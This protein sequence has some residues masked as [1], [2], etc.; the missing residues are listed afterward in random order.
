M[1]R[2]VLVLTVALMIAVMMVAMAAPAMASSPCGG[3]GWHT[4]RF[5]DCQFKNFRT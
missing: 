4:D 5:G 3:H 1:K 2:M